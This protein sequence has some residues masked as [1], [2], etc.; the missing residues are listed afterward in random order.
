MSTDNAHSK[1]WSKFFTTLT[2]CLQDA[3]PQQGLSVETAKNNDL[4]G[5]SEFCSLFVPKIWIFIDLFR[6]FYLGFGTLF[7]N[8]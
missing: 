4:G 8:F 3:Y 5:L 2:N 7:Y 1:M 6:F